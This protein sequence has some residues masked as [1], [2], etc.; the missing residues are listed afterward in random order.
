M[1]DLSLVIHE[2][3]PF[4][5]FHIFSSMN[6]AGCCACL[7]KINIL[8]ARSGREIKGQPEW[9]VTVTNNCPCTQKLIKL[10]CQGFQTVEPVSPAILSKDGD[11]CLLING[12]ELPAGSSVYFSYAWDPP[13]IFWPKDSVGVGC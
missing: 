4:N 2:E 10:T 13:I 6:I 7:D 11:T 12:K 8:T 3:V 1:I 9:D 5:W